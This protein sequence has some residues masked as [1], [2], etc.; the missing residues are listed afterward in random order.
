MARADA[1]AVIA[2]RGRDG[3]VAADADVAARS[4]PARADARAVIAARG[5][6]GAVAADADVAAR[7]AVAAADARA[8]IGGLGRDAG[9]AADGDAA[10][11]GAISAADGRTAIAAVG[12]DGAAGDGDIAAGHVVAAADGR[13]AACIDVAIDIPGVTGGERAGAAD[14]KRLAL[15]HEDGGIPAV[16]VRHRVCA[17]QQDGGVALAGDARPGVVALGLAVDGRAAERHRRAVGNRHLHPMVGV[18]VAIA[19][20]RARDQLPVLEPERRRATHVGDAARGRRHA[21]EAD[22]L[23]IARDGEV[24]VELARLERH[25][26]FED[27]GRRG[28]VCPDRHLLAADGQHGHVDARGA[29]RRARRGRDG[30]HIRAVADDERRDAVDGRAAVHWGELADEH[31]VGHRDRAA[32]RCLRAADGD[33]A[34][35][36]GRVEVGADAGNGTVLAAEYRGVDAARTVAER[37]GIDELGRAALGVAERGGD[38]SRAVGVGRAYGGRRRRVGVVSLLVIHGHLLAAH[39]CRRAA[40]IDGARLP[41]AVGLGFALW[42]ERGGQ[43]DGAVGGLLLRPVGDV[44]LVGARGGQCACRQQ[45]QGQ[46][47]C[48]L[49]CH[50]RHSLFDVVCY[51]GLPLARRRLIR[52]RGCRLSGN[53]GRGLR[54]RFRPGSAAAVSTRRPASRASHTS[55]SLLSFA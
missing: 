21:A 16:E 20:E 44:V 52:R 8:A 48:L 41:A 50:C 38:G 7:G 18:C 12:R 31:L 29:E 11:R 35:A 23:G 53:R 36:R 45:R 47:Q 5:R 17:R 10:A 40:L 28:G 25:A 51:C 14:G 30:V 43:C 46:Y 1:R 55:F 39:P 9:R 4:L 37:G 2:A 26:L 32:D 34:L 42:R 3:A 54:A 13:A 6:D 24:P 22:G 19:D 27:V 49:R 33:G 15:G